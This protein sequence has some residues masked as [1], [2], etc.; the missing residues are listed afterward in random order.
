MHATT[1]TS[2]DPDLLQAAVYWK[3]QVCVL[4]YSRWLPRPGRGSAAI[5]VGAVGSF[6]GGWSE[7]FSGQKNFGGGGK[8]GSRRTAEGGVW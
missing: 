1:A 3:A 8:Q 4:L 6:G 7:R 5:G 2:D